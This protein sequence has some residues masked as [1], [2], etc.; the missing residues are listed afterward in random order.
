M[1]D[2]AM[3][4]WFELFESVCKARF[5]GTCIY[6]QIEIDEYG[7]LDKKIKVKFDTLT[8]HSEDLLDYVHINVW[9][10]NKTVSLESHQ[11]FVS[12]IDDISRQCWVYSMR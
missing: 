10:P 1:A 4:S 9:G 12:F 3:I 6:L 2:E 11:Y 7:V 5:I 8:H